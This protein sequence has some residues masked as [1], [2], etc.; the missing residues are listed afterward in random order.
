VT[1]QEVNEAAELIH[2]EAHEDANIIWGMVIDPDV[3]DRVRVTVIATGFGE[4]AEDETTVTMAAAVKDSKTAQERLE[5]PTFARK[6]K[7]GGEVIKLKKLSVL[8][9]AEDEEKYEIPTFLRKQ[10][11]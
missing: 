9:S 10:M 5:V 2:A 1:L 7:Q 3:E 6:P 4:A 8:S 11:D